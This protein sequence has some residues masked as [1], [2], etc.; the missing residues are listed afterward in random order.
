MTVRPNLG[1]GCAAVFIAIILNL[2]IW[3]GL[4]AGA[5]WIVKAVWG[6]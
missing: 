2:A 6:S 5:V 1:T 4:I 3:A